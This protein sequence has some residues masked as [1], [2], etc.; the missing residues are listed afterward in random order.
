M[1][2]KRDLDEV[3]GV[4]RRDVVEM[5]SYA[6]SGHLTSCLSCAEIFS[7]L[8]FSQMRRGDEFVLSKGH[9][10]PIYYSALK[11]V[12]MIKDDLLG[13]RKL[14]SRLEGHPI[15]QSMKEIKFAT[16]SLGQGLGIGAGMALGFKLRGEM[17]KVYILMGDSEISEGSVYEALNFCAYYGLDNLC[18][19][20]DVN[21]LGQRGETMHGYDMEKYE[22]VLSSFGWDVKSVNGHDVRELISGIE[23][24]GK[25]GK[26]FVLLAKTVK[27]K[28]ISF[29]EGKNGWHGKA[30]NSEEA[31]RALDEIGEFKMPKIKSDF[32]TEDYKASFGRSFEIGEYS[33]DASTREAY[34]NA[35]ASLTLNDKNIIVL[36]AEV[37]NSTY[38]EKVKAKTPKQ[39]VEC[40]IAEQNMIS[41]ALGLS[42]TGFNVFSSTFSSF[43]TRAH[44]QIRMSALSSADMTICGSHCG[45]SIGEDGASQMGLEDISVFRSIPNSIVFYPS[46]AVS[47]EKIVSDCYGLKGIKYIRTTRG[48]T[49][50]IYSKRDEFPL[51]EFKIVRESKKDKFVLIGAGVTLHESIKAYEEL[52]RRGINCAVVDL[53]CVK[54]LNIKKLVKF[55]E[56][57]GKKIIVSEDHYKEGGIGEMLSFE[58]RNSGIRVKSLYVEG[59]PHSGKPEELLRKYKIDCKAIVASVNAF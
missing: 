49:P 32:K 42:K 54:P 52:K 51:G 30:L 21:R 17:K 5:T 35:L 23:R 28:G 50:L 22:R 18:L 43:L 8:F 15:P 2:S 27:G 36:D 25:S 53:Y 13:L 26:P 55:V 10:A 6:G 38:S 24:F 41:V 29:I 39:F 57:H 34:G 44:D 31:K 1:V 47:C 11:R 37:S 48:K 9:C 59:I 12:G 33:G 19:V 3:A 40:F 14:N 16:G 56:S 58:F 4:L 7:V 46:D 20:I 45:V